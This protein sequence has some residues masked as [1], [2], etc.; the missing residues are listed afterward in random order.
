MLYMGYVKQTFF[1]QEPDSS[2]T[3]CLD[4]KLAEFVKD[5]TGLE[6]TSVAHYGLFRPPHG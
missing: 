4:L 1:V 5:E 6:Q 2:W 3:V